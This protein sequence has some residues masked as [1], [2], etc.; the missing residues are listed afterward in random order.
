MEIKFTVPGQ[1]KGKQRPRICRING[2]NVTY[3]PRQTIEYEKLVRV[4]YNAV[5][6]VKFQKDEPL[7]ISILALFSIPQHASKKLKQL[8]LNGDVLPT[9][10]PDS[11]N[12]IK[13]ILDALNGVAYHDDNQVC[14][15]YFEKM[16][17]ENPEIRI[18]IRNIKE[19]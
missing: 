14:R 12:I 17:A 11:D 2:R 15:V 16:Y 10:K 3:T 13:I 19:N 7:E 9:K 8:M 1:P 6:K 4:R 5:S 18:L